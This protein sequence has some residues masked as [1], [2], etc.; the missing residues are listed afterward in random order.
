MSHFHDHHFQLSNNATARRLATR[1]GPPGNDR[2]KEPSPRHYHSNPHHLQ[3]KL[4]KLDSALDDVITTIEQQATLNPGHTGDEN[5]L[6]LR[7]KMW[8]R[9][10]GTV[11]T[12]AGDR[13]G[14][15]LD[16][17]DGVPV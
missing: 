16:M 4:K 15:R 3:A 9:E 8:R 10:L 12:G 6:L 2:D 1:N 17:T 7:F 11:R 13:I 5:D 14:Y